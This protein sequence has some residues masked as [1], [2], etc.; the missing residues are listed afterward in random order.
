MYEVV[1]IA[2]FITGTTH[3]DP[4]EAKRICTEMFWREMERIDVKEPPER[5]GKALFSVVV[6]DTSTEPLFGGKH[7]PLP[8]P[9]G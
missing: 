1:I 7:E 5:S 3:S 6:Q 8:E 2:K 4:E 9:K